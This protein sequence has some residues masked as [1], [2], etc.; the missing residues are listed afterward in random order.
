MAF[1]IHG[2]LFFWSLEETLIWFD[3][4]FI[5]SAIDLKHS[6]SDAH[7]DANEPHFGPARVCM[8]K[9]NFRILFSTYSSLGRRIAINIAALVGCIGTNYR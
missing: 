2:F 3:G 4:A 8:T 1:C 6:M 9:R 5:S 7:D